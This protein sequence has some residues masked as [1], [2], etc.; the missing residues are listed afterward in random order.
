MD[1]AFIGGMSWR[2]F[3]PILLGFVV[4]VILTMRYDKGKFDQ[5]GYGY[6][7]LILS[8]VIAIALTAL[9]TEFLTRG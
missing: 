4:L 3:L 1:W 5:G 7:I 2:I 9:V 8:V 6:R